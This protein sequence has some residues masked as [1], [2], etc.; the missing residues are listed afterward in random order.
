MIG[1]GAQ[2]RLR[3][4]ALALGARLGALVGLAGG[5]GRGRAAAP[6]RRASGCT[7]SRSGSSTRSCGGRRRGSR[8]DAYEAGGA[9]IPGSS[10][11]RTRR[12]ASASRP[13]S[14]AITSAA[15]RRIGKL[16]ALH[17]TPGGWAAP[18]RRR[19]TVALSRCSSTVSTALPRIAAEIAGRSLARLPRRLALLAGLRAASRRGARSSCATSWPRS[20]TRADVRVLAWAGAPLPLF[21][22]IAP[23]GPRGT[24]EE[25]CRG[26]RVRCALDTRERP[27]HCHHEKI[28]VVDDR[29][30]FVG[31]IDLTDRGRRPLRLAAATRRERS[32]AGTTLRARLEGPAVADVAE[33][34]RMRWHEVTGESARRPRRCPSSSAGGPHDVQVVRTVPEHVYD[35]VPRR[36]LRDPRVVPPGARG[37]RRRSSTSRTSS[38]GR[39]R[40]HAVLRGKLERPPRDGFRL[41]A[42]AAREAQHRAATT[43]VARSPS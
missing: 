30:A 12:S 26:T 16:A 19:G 10:R 5:P 13:P 11:T 17:P 37:R 38:S 4:G 33:H 21:R 23:L 43:R 3:L 36:R 42:R 28:V 32:S 7:R 35:A 1:L 29:V 41:V 14:A 39:P 9:E 24:I 22:P 27:L 8:Q 40:S 6:W 18:A 31:G 2:R 15:S 20:P 34:F 25:L